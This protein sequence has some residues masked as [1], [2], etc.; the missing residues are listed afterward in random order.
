MLKFGS[1]NDVNATYKCTVCLLEDTEIVECDFQI[2]H[3]GKYLVEHVCR[4]LNLIEKDYFGLR[5]VDASKQ[6]HWLDPAKA[7]V[8]QVKD[9]D[10]ILFSFRLKFYP[11]DPFRLKEEITRYQV[12]L[13]LK[14]DL[15]HGRLY[16]TPSEAALLGAYIVQAE[17]GD[18]DPEEH[19]ENYVSEMKIL[20]KQTQLIE[21][22][23]MELHQT[24]LKGQS[25][26]NT[27]TNF[28]KK[29]CTLDTYGID[30]H[31]VKDH[32][33]NHLY[34]GINHHGILTFQGSRKTHHFKWSEVHKLNYEGK[35]F[36]I[37]LVYQ[38]DPR[39]KKKHTVG[40]KCPTGAACRHVWR[41]AIEQMLFFTI[42]SS[43]EVPSVVSGGSFFSFGTKFRYSGRVEREI[44]EDIGPLRRE[45][46]TINR[47]SSLRRKA[48]SV[49]ATPSTPIA[50]ELGYSSLPRSNH[51]AD[52]RLDSGGGLDFT[53][54]AI[55]L[56]PVAED[57]E[58]KARADEKD[59]AETEAP[60]CNGKTTDLGAGLLKDQD[61][62]LL[63]ASDYLFR[64]S[65]DHS[66]SE[67]QLLGVGGGG[68]GGSHSHRSSRSQTPVLRSANAA[69]SNK[70]AL[71]PATASALRPPPI[72]A[73]PARTFSLLRAFVPSFILTT[74][75]LL[76]IVVVILETD[77]EALGALR[78]APEMIALRRLYYEPAK[79]FLK[80][81]WSAS[82]STQVVS[83]NVR[84]IET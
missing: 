7:I 10:P 83:T 19:V 41:C 46:P 62:L 78:R 29:A 59:S 68:G 6:R 57:Q 25:P 52:C 63:G 45:E 31:P 49:P 35:M 60:V 84:T 61:A 76:V 39:T 16:C 77:Y 5:Y 42:P 79:Q 28:L 65:M 55:P 22:K 15:L 4:Q 71:P 32:R 66:S 74:L 50:S 38:E 82:A 56:E 27:E 2:H 18:Y 3:K 17:L 43:S 12:Y 13:Q 11:P 53:D 9:M 72:S 69:A 34:L 81:K 44:L 64:E 80:S 75:S 51:S 70:L 8:K 37:H 67:S 58:M 48:S 40:F 1:K 26:E 24:Q 36:I 47:V 23:I 54:P 33:G 30:P 73:P 14:R 21:E 20:L